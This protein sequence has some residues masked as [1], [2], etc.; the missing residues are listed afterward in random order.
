[1]TDWSYSLY[2]VGHSYYLSSLSRAMFLNVT[3]QNQKLNKES[4]EYKRIL[5]LPQPLMM[6][7]HNLGS[8]ENVWVRFKQVIYA[9]LSLKLWFQ[10]NWY[11]CN[12]TKQVL[13]VTVQKESPRQSLPKVTSEAAASRCSSKQ[14]FLEISQY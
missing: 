2:F 7:I 3:V 1:M 13:K 4:N 6:N 8:K 9:E 14:V 10:S 12:I 5:L 11:F